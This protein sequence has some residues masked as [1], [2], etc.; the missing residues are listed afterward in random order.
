MAD[1]T[2]RE[3]RRHKDQAGEFVYEEG[4]PLFWS[5]RPEHG[6]SDRCLGRSFHARGTKAERGGERMQ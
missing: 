3:L 5:G 2:K 1:V 4:S 6:D